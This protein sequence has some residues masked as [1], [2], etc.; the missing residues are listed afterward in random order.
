MILFYANNAFRSVAAP[1][2]FNW[3]LIG[4]QPFHFSAL[5][6]WHGHG[7]SKFMAKRGGVHGRQGAIERSEFWGLGNSITCASWRRMRATGTSVVHF[8]DLA[9]FPMALN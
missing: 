8:G 6:N 2:L 1:I 9:A 5:L 3:L 4:A 7:L